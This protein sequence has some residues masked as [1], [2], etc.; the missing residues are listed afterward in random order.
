[1]WPELDLLLAAF[2]DGVLQQQRDG[3]RLTLVPTTPA[4]PLSIAIV[5]P[6]ARTIAIEIEG[7]TETIVAEDDDDPEDRE[8]RLLA[9]D[10][11]AAGLFGRLRV[12]RTTRGSKVVGRDFM[13]QTARGV[14]LHRRDRAGWWW[15]GATTVEVA[16]DLAPPAGIVLGEGGALPWA[17]WAGTLQPTARTP[18]ARALPVNGELDLHP[19]SP[20][21]VKP[22]VL[23]YIEACKQAGIGELR[24]VHGKG[25]GALRRTVHALLERHPDVASFRLG[26]HGEGSWGATMVTL[27]RES[28][29]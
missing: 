17:P 13:V 9:L 12:R 16:N 14:V 8:H 2:A 27:R 10:L 5:V 26:G 6:D 4:H 20:R 28:R 3:D 22:L 23:E 25:I 29:D 21:E 24:I 7:W 18:A 15:P 11:V 19:F 1:M